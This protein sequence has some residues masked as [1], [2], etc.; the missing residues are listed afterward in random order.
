MEIHHKIARSRGGPDDN[1]N[2]EGLS[3]FEHAHSHALDFVL[4][5]E[6]APRFDCRME[7]WALLPKDLQDCV[8]SE[9][10]KQTAKWNRGKPSGN[11]GTSWFYH[12]VTENHVM[13]KECPPGF[14]PGRLVTEETKRRHSASQ[15]GELNGFY[16]KT[17]TP[18]TRATIGR[19]GW[20]WIHNSNGERRQL[21]PGSV[22]PYGFRLGT[23]P[24]QKN[25]TK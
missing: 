3:L 10:S 8:R 6:I 17:H 23:G 20:F 13:C 7:G 14:V 24:R 9:L 2:L 21:P 12:P 5:P 18:H 1:W 22:V 15:S 16:G 25:H 11:S 19:K 4:F